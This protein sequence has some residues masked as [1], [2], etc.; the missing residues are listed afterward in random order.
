MKS[1]ISLTIATTLLLAASG[2]ALA[3]GQPGSSAGVMCA[4]SPTAL[5]T[6]GSAGSAINP[7]GS[8]GSPFNQAVP[9]TYAGNAGNPTTSNGH[10]SS[11]AVSQYD[12]ACQ[13][14]STQ[15]P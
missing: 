4:V 11:N 6:P 8:N 1:V 12:I 9:K 15:V 3:T 5:Q 10:A 14:V 13:N 2:A 7:S